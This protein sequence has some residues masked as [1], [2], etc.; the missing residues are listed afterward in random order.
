MCQAPAASGAVIP[1]SRYLARA[2][3]K[4]PQQERLDR[5]RSSVP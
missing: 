5:N 2:V 1:E 4:Q 3:E